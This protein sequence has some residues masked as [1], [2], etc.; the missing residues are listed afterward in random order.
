MSFVYVEM[1]YFTRAP[2]GKPFRVDVTFDL[3]VDAACQFLSGQHPA[4]LSTI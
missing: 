4:W 1:I 3:H 2:T